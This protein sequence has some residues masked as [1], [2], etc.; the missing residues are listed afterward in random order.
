MPTR[1]RS[2]QYARIWWR[3]RLRTAGL[4]CPRWRRC[5]DMTDMWMPVARWRSSTT[6]RWPGPVQYGQLQQGLVE[7]GPG[8][9]DEGHGVPDRPP[10]R[11][12]LGDSDAPAIL[13]APL[14]AGCR[15]ELLEP[16]K[17]RA[18]PG[19]AG[20]WPHRSVR[21]AEQ[22]VAL[23]G[24]L[25]GGDV[26][27]QAAAPGLTTYLTLSLGVGTSVCVMLAPP[28][29]WPSATFRP[30]S[31]RAS[32]CSSTARG[33]TRPDTADGVPNLS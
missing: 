27:D 32:R 14:D 19:S 11:P 6:G 23:V 1:S 33:K 29:S 9:L 13:S 12:V 8:V 17:R 24:L 21:P 28:A 3:M 31:L 22:P 18:G 4:A 30:G 7:P 15:V 20:G 25:E 10:G 26:L 5:I 16:H 2:R